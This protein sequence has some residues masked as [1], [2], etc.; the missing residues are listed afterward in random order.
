MVNLVSWATKSVG[1]NN[2]ILLD[3][4]SVCR[5]ETDNFS[6]SA[7]FAKCATFEGFDLV[8]DA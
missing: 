3:A 5:K 4:G 2:M 8:H 1:P 6:R 7:F